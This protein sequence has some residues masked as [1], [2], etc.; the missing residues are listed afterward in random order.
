VAALLATL[1]GYAPAAAA[2]AVKRPGT[3]HKKAVPVPTCPGVGW[4]GNGPHML[5]DDHQGAASELARGIDALICS[6]ADGATIDIKSWFV[7]ANGTAMAHMISALRLMHT[8]HRVHINVFV[9]KS[10]YPP[11]QWT[12]FR[13]AFSFATVWSC[14]RACMSGVPGSIDHSKWITVSQ[15]AARNGGGPVVL[16]TSLNPT[17]EQFNS[18]QSGI[19][20][21]RDPTVYGPFMAEWNSMVRCASGHGCNYRIPAG[22]WQGKYQTKVWFEPSTLDPTHEALKAL[23]CTHG[24]TI[25]MMS[26]Y[27]YR[28]PVLKD[29]LRLRSEGCTVRVVLEHWDPTQPAPWT[30]LGPRCAFNH[31]KIVVIDV[32]S[33]HEVIAG[34]QDQLGHEVFIDD[35]QMILTTNPSPVAKYRAYF[36]HEWNEATARSCATGGWKG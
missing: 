19:A 12:A 2:Q 25:E 5:Q 13:K 20:I 26:L 33:V 30:D 14:A 9:A 17:E 23:H 3:S 11:S 24:G 15:L 8:Y 16:S 4:P 21:Y 31:D 29:L 10:W 18:G 35:N 28:W 1:I 7:G 27:M 6:A 22:S 32:G 36:A 34:S